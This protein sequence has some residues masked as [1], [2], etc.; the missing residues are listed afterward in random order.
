MALRSLAVSNPRGEGWSLVAASDLS[1][2]GGKLELMLLEP[3]RSVAG[4]ALRLGRLV[5]S[6]LAKGP[7]HLSFRLGDV[8]AMAQAAPQVKLYLCLPLLASV[9]PRQSQQRGS[10]APDSTS[11]SGTGSSCPSDQPQALQGSLLLGTELDT[12]PSRR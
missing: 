9:T 7:Q 8:A 10:Q 4:L 6:S 5:Q 12:P 1:G 11:A 2:V 3:G